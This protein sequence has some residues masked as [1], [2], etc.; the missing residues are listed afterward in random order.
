MPRLFQKVKKGK[1]KSNSNRLIE[2]RKSLG[3]SQRL[4]AEEWYVAIGLISMWETGDREMPG[5][6]IRLLEI[7]EDY[8]VS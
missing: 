6:L 2:L 3:F 5:H 7:Y 4:M 8:S 1:R